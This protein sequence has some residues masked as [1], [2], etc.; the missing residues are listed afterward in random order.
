[1]SSD[2]VTPEPR[3]W[4]ERR[5]RIPALWFWFLTHSTEK[6]INNILHDKEHL[7]YIPIT[8]DCHCG[9]KECVTKT[10][11][12][13]L[14]KEED[15]VELFQKV[16]SG[17]C[18]DMSAET[19][20][21]DDSILQEITDFTNDEV[22]RTSYARKQ[23]TVGIYSAHVFV[24]LDFRTAF[25]TLTMCYV[26][27]KSSTFMLG[28]RPYDL[29]L[30]HKR[31]H[32][33]DAALYTKYVLWIRVFRSSFISFSGYSTLLA[34]EKALARNDTKACEML[35]PTLNKD[36]NPY[37]WNEK[38]TTLLDKVF[39]INDDKCLDIIIPFFKR[40]VFNKYK[41]K[42]IYE[43]VQRS[44]GNKA[45]LQSLLRHDVFPVSTCLS[46]AVKEDNLDIVQLLKD[47]LYIKE[48]KYCVPLL[49]QATLNYSDNMLRVLLGHP[50]CRLKAKWCGGFNILVYT[51]S[52]Y[53]VV[54][55]ARDLGF[56]QCLEV[57]VNAG[58][59]NDQNNAK[60]LPIINFV[61]GVE[62]TKYS[63]AELVNRLAKSGYGVNTCIEC[64]G[65]K[66]PPIY[67]AIVKK[68]LDMIKALLAAGA[69]LFGV[70]D[71]T[72]LGCPPRLLAEFIH[73]N[74]DICTEKGSVLNSILEVQNPNREKLL[75]LVLNCA[76]TIPRADR[77]RF[78]ELSKDMSFYGYQKINEFLT[79]TRRL[80]LL[81]RDALRRHYGHRIHAYIDTECLPPI[82]AD[83]LNC[84]QALKPFLDRPLEFT[85]AFEPMDSESF[86]CYFP[87]HY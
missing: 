73:H 74:A 71:V 87:E 35:V 6:D 1:M 86:V 28:F 7:K 62:S 44:F 82:I 61:Y 9:D 40:E 38:L 22:T 42:C 60:I 3:V 52:G 66:F 14:Q 54:Q 36:N 19:P 16:A 32:M 25:H 84:R 69:T 31:Y 5:R 53:S 39:L 46:I 29:M 48:Q 56:T 75:H 27:F 59:P 51:Y 67:D 12:C 81:S 85:K 21:N 58:L 57:L 26:A 11:Y 47:K 64:G 70:K 79:S 10:E 17:T 33:L 77:D 83:F 4:E 45:V 80:T 20:S 72:I 23:N 78:Q 49:V 63:S 2:N 30:E 76:H 37:I 34:C 68:E 15:V 8:Y 43:L 50:P 13:R 18:T 55:L 65:T 41:K 24:A